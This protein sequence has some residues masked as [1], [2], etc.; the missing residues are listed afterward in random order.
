MHN[1]WVIHQMMILE[2][3]KQSVQEEDDYDCEALAHRHTQS[4]PLLMMILPTMC[5]INKQTSHPQ[6]AAVGSMWKWE[7]TNRA[8]AGRLKRVCLGCIHNHCLLAKAGCD[9]ATPHQ[10]FGGGG[11]VSPFPR[12]VLPARPLAG[13]PVAWLSASFPMWGTTQAHHQLQVSALLESVGAVRRPDVVTIPQYHTT[14]CWSV[15]FQ[16]CLQPSLYYDYHHCQWR[17]YWKPPGWRLHFVVCTHVSQLLLA[18]G[19]LFSLSLGIL[20]FGCSNVG[21]QIFEC[22]SKNCDIF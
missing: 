7:Y 8:M 4:F 11:P 15:D 14:V 21:I 19:L 2:T 18:H 5:S 9:S 6:P 3:V 12:L 16:A 1:V 17:E 20:T 22:L 10:Q 13:E